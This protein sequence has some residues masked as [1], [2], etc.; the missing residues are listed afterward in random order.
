[1]DLAQRF[2]EIRKHTTFIPYRKTTEKNIILRL[3]VSPLEYEYSEVP[4]S[5]SVKGLFWESFTVGGEFYHFFDAGN[6]E[7]IKRKWLLFEEIEIRT[8]H[9]NDDSKQGSQCQCVF[10][11]METKR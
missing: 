8:I 1:M 2:C 10:P 5:Q 6:E 7:L 11:N 9:I 3:E 4:K